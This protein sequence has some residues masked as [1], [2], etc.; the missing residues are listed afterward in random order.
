MTIDTNGD[1]FHPKFMP[2]CLNDLQ[3]I[4]PMDSYLWWGKNILIALFA[5][6]FLVFGIETLIGSFLLKNPLEFIIYFFSSSFMVLVSLVG[7][8]YPTLKIYALFKTRK[9]SN[10]PR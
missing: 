6:F 9:H 4:R 7:I 1:I 5:L 10:D 3:M 2:L 8:L